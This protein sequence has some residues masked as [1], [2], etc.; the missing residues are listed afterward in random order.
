MFQYI[1]LG[2]FGAV[3][4]AAGVLW[5][6]F[7]EAKADW[8][9]RTLQ[10][11]IFAGAIL[12]AWSS[13]DT[14]REQAQFEGETRSRLESVIAS[15][16]GGDSFCHLIVLTDEKSGNGGRLMVSHGGKFPLYDVSARITDL[17]KWD[18]IKGQITWDLIQ[19]T[20]TRLNLGNMIPGHASVLGRWEFFR[21][22]RQR[23]NIFFSARNGSFDQNLRFVKVEGKWTVASRVLRDEIVIF[24][25]VDPKFPRRDDGSIEW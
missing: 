20:D 7:S 14:A 21:T 17:E 25:E 18:E 13:V 3:L 10:T 24:E 11:M 12:S 15:V 8:K 2:F 16:I 5:L 23:Y 19:K 6:A 1:D 4:S 9:E 22:D